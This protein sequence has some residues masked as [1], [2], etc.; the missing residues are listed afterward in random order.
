MEIKEDIIT[1]ATTMEDILKGDTT[2]DHHHKDT[3]TTTKETKEDIIKNPTIKA[4]VP[5]V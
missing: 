1:K 2:M 4:V 5:L 3:T